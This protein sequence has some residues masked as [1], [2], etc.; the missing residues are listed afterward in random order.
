MSLPNLSISCVAA[1]NSK[2]SKLDIAITNC[3]LWLLSLHLHAFLASP[4]RSERITVSLFSAYPSVERL[5]NEI[6]Q[7]R[8]LKYIN[9]LV[10]LSNINK[11][12]FGNTN[13]VP[14]K[15][16]WK[17]QDRLTLARGKDKQ[18]NSQININNGQKNLQNG[19]DG[20]MEHILLR[21]RP[22]LAQ[23]A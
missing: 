18:Q 3:H 22:C 15:Y 19:V 14:L 20:L 13:F 23:N 16:T 11:V 5:F 21:E 17:P 10:F 1:A 6:I 12:V 9:Q 7:P 8:N 4:F 2:Y